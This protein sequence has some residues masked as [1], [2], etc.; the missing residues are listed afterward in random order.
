MFDKKKKKRIT[1]IKFCDITKNVQRYPLFQNY[2]R[3][4]T[5]VFKSIENKYIINLCNK[6][7]MKYQSHVN[8]RYNF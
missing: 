6:N 7:V 8:P 5:Q 3:L 4:A 2:Y 1:T